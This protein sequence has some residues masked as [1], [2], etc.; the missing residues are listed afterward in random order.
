MA[1]AARGKPGPK[2]KPFRDALEMQLKAA[3]DNHKALRRIADK[4]I[5][6]ADA[7][8]LQAIREIADRQDGKVPQGLVGGDDGDNE[9]S[10]TVVNYTK[11]SNTE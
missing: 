11:P 8:D 7:G 3:G 10:I 1:L 4:L 5:S 6:L 9:L 2:H